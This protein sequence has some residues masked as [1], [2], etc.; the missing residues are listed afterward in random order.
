MS[1]LPYFNIGGTQALYLS[2]ISKNPDIFS[3]R[4]QTSYLLHQQVALTLLQLHLTAKFQ[5][6]TSQEK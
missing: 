1:L 2:H 6:K 3:N 4:P 5:N